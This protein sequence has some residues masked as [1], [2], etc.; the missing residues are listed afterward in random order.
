MRMRMTRKERR[1]LRTKIDEAMEACRYTT[2]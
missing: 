2:I 1:S